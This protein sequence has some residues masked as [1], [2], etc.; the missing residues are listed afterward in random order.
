M[1]ISKAEKLKAL[2]AENADQISIPNG[3]ALKVIS[4]QN[5]FEQIDKVFAEE[6]EGE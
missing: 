2:I 1:K 4:V 3:Y 6:D 5:C